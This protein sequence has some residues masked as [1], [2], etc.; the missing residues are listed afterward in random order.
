MN[1]GG[2]V[3]GIN[4]VTAMLLSRTGLFQKYRTSAE[5]CRVMMLGRQTMSLVNESQKKAVVDSFKNCGN[6]DIREESMLINSYSENFLTDVGSTSIDSLDYSEFEKCSIIRN[7]NTLFSNDNN[8]NKIKEKYD[9]VLDLGTSEHIFNSS[10]SIANSIFMLKTGGALLLVLPVSG[11]IEHG[12]YQFSPNFFRSLEVDGLILKKLYIFNPY[13]DPLMIWDGEE[14]VN[15]TL[16]ESMSGRFSSFAIYEKCKSF[17]QDFFLTNVNQGVYVNAW[18]KNKE[19]MPKASIRKID[20]I[21]WLKRVVAII[22]GRS[23]F[24]KYLVLLKHRVKIDD[25]TKIS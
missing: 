12:F 11:W 16:Y 22:F 5:K 18:S 1:L 17:N 24:Y 25:I 14:F 8:N 4:Y 19:T 23:Y 6:V 2:C 9:I 7:L 3:L 20:I 21:K 10:I 13:S 15:I